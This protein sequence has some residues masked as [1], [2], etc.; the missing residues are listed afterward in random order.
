M[1]FLSFLNSF[2]S[3]SNHFVHAQPSL[4]SFA[5][6][7]ASLRPQSFPI[8]LSN[9][10]PSPS[11]SALSLSALPY[12]CLPLQVSYTPVLA[13]VFNVTQRDAVPSFGSS[14]LYDVFISGTLIKRLVR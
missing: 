3:F 10:R 9:P 1:S 2:P 4:G 13:S 5:L 12:A 8:S 14:R 6:F 11:H 7:L